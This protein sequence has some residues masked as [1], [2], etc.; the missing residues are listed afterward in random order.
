MIKY[1]IN[2]YFDKKNGQSFSTVEFEYKKVP[3]Q[4]KIYISGKIDVVEKLNSNK[5]VALDF[6]LDKF[7]NVDLSSKINFVY[8]GEV[9]D[10]TQSNDILDI[11]LNMSG[12]AESYRQKLNLS[13]E[14]SISDIF[15]HISKHAT[16]MHEDLMKKLKESEDLKNVKTQE[17]KKENEQEIV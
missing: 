17:I 13:D 3:M 2:E 7:L 1:R 10:R 6:I 11:A 15:N 12:L 8:N 5:N 14:L 16:L 4:E 9:I